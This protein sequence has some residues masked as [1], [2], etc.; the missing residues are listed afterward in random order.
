VRCRGLGGETARLASL[1]PSA[2]QPPKLQ[3]GRVE[4]TQE[5]LAAAKQ[6]REAAVPSLTGE[7]LS[8]P[9]RSPGRSRGCPGSAACAIERGAGFSGARET[10]AALQQ[11]TCRQRGRQQRGEGDEAAACGG[12]S[13]EASAGVQ[14]Q[15]VAALQGHVAGVVLQAWGRLEAVGVKA[16]QECFG[17]CVC[18][19]VW[20][21]QQLGVLES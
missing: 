8:S 15:H 18:V 7:G 1:A 9:P 12:A 20:G 16:C 2:G 4:E 13:L 21:S 6:S 17:V 14:Q 5:Q 19:L 11:R 3:A 10:K